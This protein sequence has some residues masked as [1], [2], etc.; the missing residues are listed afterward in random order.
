ML[1][2]H[3]PSQDKQGNPSVTTTKTYHA[4]VDQVLKKMARLHN[5]DLL[6]QETVDQFTDAVDKLCETITDQVGPILEAQEVKYKAAQKM[7]PGDEL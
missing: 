1:V 7:E 6:E 3:R 5:L 2:E 4:N